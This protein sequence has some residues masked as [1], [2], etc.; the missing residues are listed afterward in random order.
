MAIARCDLH[1]PAGRTKNY[2]HRVP[3]EGRGLGCGQDRCFNDGEIWLT[4]A[5]FA[6][7]QRGETV[8]SPDSQL[9]SSALNDVVK[10]NA[11]NA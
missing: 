6:E 10:V 9:R 5:E 7:Y 8:F 3:T 2:A 1:P 4:P 11:S